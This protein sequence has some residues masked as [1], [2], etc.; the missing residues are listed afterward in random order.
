M[1]QDRLRR[2]ASSAALALLV[3]TLGATVTQ[4]QNQA[5]APASNQTPAPNQAAAPNQ[6][7]APQ[8]QPTTPTFRSAV[9]YVE[10][11][12][13]V[14]DNK[15]APIRNLTKDDFKLLE[16]GAA[17]VIETFAVIDIPNAAPSAIATTDAP[18]VKPDVAT[19]AGGGDRPSPGRLFVLFLD[20]RQIAPTRTQSTIRV[21]TEF[22]EK[23]LGP[24]DQV[25]LVT[26]S[27]R[28]DVSQN[29]TT[30]K[31]VVAERV[32]NFIGRKLEPLAIQRLQ[33]QLYIEPAAT[34]AAGVQTPTTENDPLLEAEHFQEARLALQ[35]IE[36]VCNWL[37]SIKGVTKSLVLV[38]EGVDYDYESDPV[39]NRW[40]GEILAQQRITMA[41]ATR[42]NVTVYPVDPRGLGRDDD[43][44]TA[45]TAFR[46]DD[47]TF[48][49]RAATNM[50]VSIE[51]ALRQEVDRARTTLREI[52]DTTGGIE[53]VGTNN[54]EMALSK[55]VQHSSAYYLIGYH[56]T[57][58]RRQGKFRTIKVSVARPG[59]VINARR[60]YG[61]PDAVAKAST[62]VFASP[63]GASSAVTEVLNSP[64]PL[65][66]LTLSTTA[67]AFRH[68][69]ERASVAV[70]VESPSLA[71]TE[72][73]GKYVSSLE[74]ITA[75]IDDRNAI[76]AGQ[77]GQ[78]N[79]GVTAQTFQQ[80]KQAGFRTLAQL[81]DLKPGHYEL[82][83]AVVD[84]D[85]A[86]R[87]SVSYPFDVPDFSKGKLQMSGLL[88]SS[89]AGSRT[90][91]Y[92][93]E[94]VLGDLT[95]LPPTTVREFKVGDELTVV[96]EIYD[97]ELKIDHQVDLTTTLKTAD[98]KEAFSTSDWAS[99]DEITAANGLYRISMWVP[100]ADVEPGAYTLSIEALSK[101]SDDE[102]PVVKSI[103]IQIVK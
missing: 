81:N 102:K 35:A 38:S 14:T 75:A 5:P 58:T 22:L 53:S 33:A 103:P 92:N 97:N 10:V 80:V 46:G 23:H 44:I 48:D 20:D 15:G 72:K 61:E 88:V 82:R 28:L 55:I 56:P 93:N 16:D 9:Q 39:H 100:L 76:A 90:P 89:L 65:N 95:T 47:G 24:T 78:L 57:N 36:S 66:E 19:N 85:T 27:G 86:R 84:K 43:S 40:S 34:P 8:D 98:G 45:S 67:V 17:Q 11:D 62:P 12:V 42:A 1:P 21:A 32:R 94:K 63:A 74:I 101:V 37:G 2:P 29:F 87:G 70:I 83:I 64:L 69:S 59:A 7:P 6:A 96:A 18:K 4:T 3:L 26:S 68:N 31:Q 52:A 25:A 71:F 41:A 30:N 99:F 77:T 79:L 13:R 49:A 54:F 60:G 91:T 73:D 51:T 50:P